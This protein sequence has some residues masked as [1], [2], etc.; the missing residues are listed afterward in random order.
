MAKTQQDVSIYKDKSFSTSQSQF[1][2]DL[3]KRQREGWRLVSVTP[4]K[5]R[6]FGRIVQLT[7]IYE[8]DILDGSDTSAA[9]S[10]QAKAMEAARRAEKKAQARTER[11][12]RFKEAQRRARE[13]EQAYRNSL[14][15]EQ[16]QQYLKRKRRITLIAAAVVVVALLL[17][18]AVTANNPAIQALLTSVPTDTPVPPTP[19]PTRQAT[20]APTQVPTPKPT[21]KPAPSFAQFGDGTFVVGKDIQPGTYR[22]RTGSPGCYFARLSGFGGTVDEIIANANTDNPAIVTIAASDK[23]FQ[24]TNC[25]T[26]TKD[27]SAITTSKTSFSDGMYIIGTDIGPGTYKSSGQQGCYYARLSGFGGTVDDIISNANTDTAAIVTISASDKG[28]QSDSC[29]TWTRQ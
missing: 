9:T 13:K 7:A 12:E 5:K 18:I 22:T 15:P 14:S 2:K 11:R 19:A 29:G 3:K 21:A 1:E 6:G 10:A 28:F 23:G 20:S 27:L 16:L 26:W 17:G 8:K 25:G 24:S 4:T